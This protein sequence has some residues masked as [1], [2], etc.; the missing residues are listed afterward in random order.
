M[1]KKAL[2]MEISTEP[3]LSQA[4]KAPLLNKPRV[5]PFVKWAG[6]KRTLTSDIEKILP[7]EFNDYYEPFLGG[8]S[9]FFTLHHK[10]KKA[11]LSDL[12]KNL[13]LTYKIL[14][15]EPLKLIQKLKHYQ[16]NHSKQY[17]DKLRTKFNASPDELNL[18]SIFIYLNKTCFNGLYRVN[19]SGLFNVPIGRYKNPGICHE[20]NLKLASKA[21]KKAELKTQS[22]ECI[23]PM[24][25]DVVYCDPPYDNTFSSYTKE[26]F[27][28]ES[29]EL[30]KQY[31]DKWRKRGVFTIISN[32]DTLFIRKLYKGYR[33][34]EVKMAR[35]I[36]CKAQNR[37]AVNE[38]LILS[39]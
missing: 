13:M 35:N 8:G 17:Y 19:Q 36:N 28:N 37:N 23:E 30:L 15:K 16:K 27:N 5:L 11:Y 39:N 25:K 9:V 10:I 12:N 7:W 2:Y 4:L 38:L 14:K 33:F 1:L 18:A 24:K 3:N 20:E 34:I 32:S 29:Q 31:C 26:G 22:F 6:G 21:L